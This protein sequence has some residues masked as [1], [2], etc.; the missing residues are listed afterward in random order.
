MSMDIL[1]TIR[2]LVKVS[3]GMIHVF[4]DIV[5]VSMDMINVPYARKRFPQ[6]RVNDPMI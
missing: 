2:A 1:N 4:P 6:D 3:V 5:Q